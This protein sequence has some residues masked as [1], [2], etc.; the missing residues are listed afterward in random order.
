MDKMFMQLHM[1]PDKVIWVDMSHVVI[2]EEA[3]FDDGSVGTKLYSDFD[4]SKY[5]GVSESPEVII[6]LAREGMK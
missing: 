6:A 2:I 5:V 1:G 3:T 4:Q